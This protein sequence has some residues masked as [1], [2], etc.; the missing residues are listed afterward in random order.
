MTRD[1]LAS[2]LA[3]AASSPANF[4]EGRFDGR[5]IVICAG[6][7]RL[8]T[9]AW[10]CIGMLR[11]LGCTL[12]VEVW[13]LGPEELGAPMRSLLAGLGAETVDAHAVAKRHPVC[14]LGGWELKPYA[15]LHSRFRQVLLLDA[16]NV[17]V[18]DPTGLFD[19]ADFRATG[20]MFWPDLLRLSRSNPIWTI[21]RLE[22][23]DCESFESGQVL[24]DKPRS[25]RA[26][27]LAHWMN[28][29]SDDLYG[30][31][32]G[33]K[34]T[35]LIAWLMLGERYHLIPH[36]P[37]Q[38]EATIC[39]RGP[40]GSVLFQHRNGAKWV[41][42][43]INPTIEGFRREPECFDLLAELET[44]W[45]GYVFNPPTRSDS[46]MALERCLVEGRRFRYVRVSSD[47]RS[48]ELLPDHR[49][50]G[51]GGDEFYW[52]ADEAERGLEIV[53][54]GNGNSSN[55]LS[56]SPDGVWR[57]R[58]V[59]PPGTPVELVPMLQDTSRIAPED[60]T[61]L[62]AV[63]DR[64][65]VAYQSLP[66]DRETTRDFIGLVRGFA[67][68]D[69]AIKDRLDALAIGS[70]SDKLRC[71]IALALEGWADRAHRPDD[72]GIAAGHGWQRHSFPI[73]GYDPAT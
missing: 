3:A 7:A 48:I 66:L 27:S 70:A 33:D 55:R 11:R 46:A 56:L 47:E 54:A 1:D 62:H 24:F 40:D 65:L 51:A 67:L 8:F 22:A 53:L 61:P 5:G 71:L 17:P 29:H 64:A 63:L 59:H 52:Y 9:C 18:K 42:Q 37:K 57:G 2:A 19:D 73:V 38:L 6:G 32:H 58:L 34:D 60:R 28:Q 39:Q 50:G 21:A 41:L 72:G 31:I 23:R 30:V 4:P 43:G 44:V 13:H 36:Q 10:I 12:P 35:F 16:D 68:L 15:V 45:D 26:L 20:A 69:P 49:I 14:R 25:W